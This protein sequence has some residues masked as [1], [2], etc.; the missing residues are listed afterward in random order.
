MKL[1]KIAKTI[2]IRCANKIVTFLFQIFISV[3]CIFQYGDR[4]KFECEDAGTP[5]MMDGYFVSSSKTVTLQP[6]ELITT[7]LNSEA[8]LRR[9]A[10]LNKLGTK[11]DSIFN[12]VI[13][14]R[15]ITTFSDNETSFFVMTIFE[16]IKKL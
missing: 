4:V 15:V 11:D 2:F 10:H 12:V 13:Q 14:S 9:F 1:N 5:Y 6:E 8:E 7:V 3:Y 16:F